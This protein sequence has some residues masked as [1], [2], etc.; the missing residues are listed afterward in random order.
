MAIRAVSRRPWTLQARLVVAL[1]AVAA[2]GLT[3]V[4]GASVVLLR[5][6][7]I[8]RVD[9]QLT[10]V[11]RQWR[12]RP[13]KPRLHPP[14]QAGPRDLPTD[15]RVILLGQDG[16]ELTVVGELAGDTSGPALPPLDQASALQ[17]DGIPFT[18]PD[19]TG[20]GSWRVRVLPTPAGRT[21][22]TAQ[23]LATVDLTVERLLR[24]EIAVGAVVLALLGVVAAVVVRIGLRPLTR[25]ERTAAAIAAGD[26]DRRLAGDDSHTETGRLARALNTMLGRLGSA[27][28]EREE[29]E[30]RLR[31]FVGDAS[32]ELRT[33]LTSIRGF[34]ELYRRGGAPRREDVDRMMCRIES[35]ARR[36]GLLVEDLLLLARLDR[37]RP[38][39]LTDVDLVA[40]AGDAAQDARA[41]DP[42]R[43]VRLAVGGEAVHV[44]GDEHRLRQV[45]TN[46]VTNA[47]RHTPA[48]AAVEIRVGWADG[49]PGRRG[50]VF[51]VADN[52]PGIPP[53][54]AANVFDRFY[55]VDP[56]RSRGRGGTGLGLAI[57]AAIVAAH[58]GRVELITEQGKGTR[59]RVWLPADATI[60]PKDFGRSRQTPTTSPFA[61]PSPAERDVE[62]VRT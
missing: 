23:S 61:R 46:L 2:V 48:Q 41:H 21:L 9:E 3:A 62:G 7:L 47:V 60:Q 42:E 26:L 8:S 32:H 38:L 59:F 40:L 31:R 39:N 35:E 55:R 36:M 25:I 18:V 58:H 19:R 49:P 11:L 57:T 52:G 15:F 33:P 50:A 45:I 44:V 10:G 14:G 28:R 6:S 4:G 5:Q 17:R 12:V 29:S 20:G 56:S 43:Q 16:T 24:I 1:L 37:E 13:I 54:H 22:V 34:A 27:F 53:E 30:R 51:E